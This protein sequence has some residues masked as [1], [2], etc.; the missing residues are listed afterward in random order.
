MSRL[1]DACRALPDFDTLQIVYAPH[2]IPPSGNEF[3]R[4]E[5]ELL[6]SRR[7][8][9]Q[10]LLGEQVKTMKDWV[11]EYLKRSKVGHHEAEG[12]GTTLSIIELGPVYPQLPW[13][14]EETLTRKPVK[15][16]VCE[17]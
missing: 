11:T 2:S 9:Q 8:Q 10:V 3:A 1:I 13:S 12:R 17:V 5:V 15:V 14:G 16:E 4:D 7:Q 6:P